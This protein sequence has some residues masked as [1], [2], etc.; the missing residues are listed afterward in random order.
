MINQ[1]KYLLKLI[2]LGQMQKNPGFRVEVDDFEVTAN[3]SVTYLGCILDKLSGETMEL[4]VLS[5]VNQKI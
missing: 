4:R 5:K 2:H 3:E 1:K